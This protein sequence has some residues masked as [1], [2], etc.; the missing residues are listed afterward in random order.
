LRILHLDPDAAV[1]SDLAAELEAAGHRVE[2]SDTVADAIARDA[3][4]RCDLV[5]T[6]VR[7][8]DGGV[9]D[10]L[11][12]LRLARGDGLPPIAV[13]AGAPEP[14]L[15]EL[16]ERAGVRR[17]L[18]KSDDWLINAAELHGLLSELDPPR[19][20][21]APGASHGA[22]PEGPARV[23]RGSLDSV[24]LVEVVQLLNLGRKSGTL[25]LFGGSREGRLH[26]REGDVVAAACG[27]SSGAEAFRALLGA[28][29]GSFR[30]EVGEAPVTR[31][32][33]EPTGSLLL[34]ALRREDEDG[35]APSTGFPLDGFADSAA[36]GF[37]DGAADEVP[38]AAAGGFA[39]AVA[40]GFHDGAAGG[41]ADA[42]GAEFAAD[43][44][45]VFGGA[46]CR[47]PA[48]GSAGADAGLVDGFGP[49]AFEGFGDEAGASGAA[50][51]P[52]CAEPAHA[53][54][55]PAPWAP[56]I[57][58]LQPVAGVPRPASAVPEPAPD[59]VAADVLPVEAGQRRTSGVRPPRL[60][61]DRPGRRWR[62]AV[63]ARVWL[64][65]GGAAAALAAGYA[66]HSAGAR[67]EADGH[68]LER[69][70]VRTLLLQAA[71]D[72]A[73]IDS[74]E[75]VVKELLEASRAGSDAGL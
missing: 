54:S 12:R 72:Q 59:A 63:S 35:R 73:R 17:F 46:A 4:E 15:A 49:G 36:G 39:D 55:A 2:S 47:T 43:L 62:P 45:G 38:D 31:T 75:A 33:H 56:A 21:S 71:A 52:A 34:D 3:A 53:E 28:R 6:E 18:R 51:K 64:V 60:L 29:G 19:R 5:V 30:F 57:P 9:L 37:P 74:L 11:R 22:Q 42:S 61:P 44:G 24:D 70:D 26:L 16:C 48:S 67:S 7:L 69:E 40:G 58:P 32:I 23:F 25:L 8:A 1:R 13:L 10:L 68:E 20:P 14:G 41:C 65:A 50:G 66:V 27:A